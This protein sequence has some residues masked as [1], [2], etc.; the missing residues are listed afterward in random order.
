MLYMHPMGV[1]S[2]KSSIACIRGG[3][4]VELELIGLSF[5]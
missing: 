1:E 5:K 4:E 2:T 3:V